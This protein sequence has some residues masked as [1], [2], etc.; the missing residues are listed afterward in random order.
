MRL[1]RGTYYSRL[2]LRDPI[3]SSRAVKISGL[4]LP[5]MAGEGRRIDRA[6][7][8]VASEILDSDAVRGSR[9]VN[10]N[11]PVIIHSDIGAAGGTAD[12]IVNT[13]RGLHHVLA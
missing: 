2:L 13:Q 6:A 3:L 5:T 7:L 9:R 1:V 10:I 8:E 4:K 12:Y 11:I